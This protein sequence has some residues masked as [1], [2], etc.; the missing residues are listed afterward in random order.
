MVYYNIKN[1]I[2]SIK[3]KISH[4]FKFSLINRDANPCK[5]SE[6]KEFSKEIRK[7]SKIIKKVTP[8]KRKEN[9]YRKI[10]HFQLEKKDPRF[11]SL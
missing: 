1:Y 10:C 8:G 6:A 5:I 11:Y 2:N 7:F 9:P 4:D 3:A